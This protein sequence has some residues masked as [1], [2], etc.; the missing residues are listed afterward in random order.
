MFG[1]EVSGRSFPEIGVPGGHHSYS[2][3]QNAPENLAMLA[4][5]NTYHIRQFAYFL[6]RMQA[7]PDGDGSLL[8]HSLFVYG[9]GISDGNL[10]FHLDLP[11]LLAGGAAGRVQG[12][13]HLRY[14]SDTP[15]AN[16]HVAVL[17]KLGLPVDAFG[18]STGALGYLSDV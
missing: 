15:I 10:H 6:E 1:K 9:S 13:R 16:L 14:A 17:D 18:D 2:H 11:T 12:G 4:R 3:H 5:I 7:T 8:D